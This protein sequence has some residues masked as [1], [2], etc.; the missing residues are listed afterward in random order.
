[1][2]SVWAPKPGRRGDGCAAWASIPSS[3][4]S[5][6]STE[7]LLHLISVNIWP[8]VA[9]IFPMKFVRKRE[10]TFPLSLRGAMVA[11]VTGRPAEQKSSPD[12]GRMRPVLA[13]VLGMFGRSMTVL[14]VRFNGRTISVRSAG[15]LILLIS[16]LILWLT[17]T[18]DPSFVVGSSVLPVVGS[19]G[20]RERISSGLATPTVAGTSTSG[21]KRSGGRACLSH[22][23]WISRS[24][25]SNA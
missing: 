16:L 3:T 7:M 11:P 17:G 1:M 15:A 25:G 4:M 18:F 5:V 6:S 21:A 13:R 12:V 23:L 20:F 14:A 10:K 2:S 19:G 22:V 24:G 9:T 8:R